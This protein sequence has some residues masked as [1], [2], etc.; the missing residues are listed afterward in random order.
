[1]SPLKLIQKKIVRVITFSDKL[2]HT[3]PLFKQLNIL[4]LN[5]LFFL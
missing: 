3:A 1:M 2:A 4:P 5:K